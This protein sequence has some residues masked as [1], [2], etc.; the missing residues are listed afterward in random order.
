MRIAIDTVSARAGGGQTYLRNLLSHD[1]PFADMSVTVLAVPSLILPSLGKGVERLDVDPRAANPFLRFMW[2]W[3]VPRLLQD[4]QADVL[5]AP[6]GILAPRSGDVLRV[7]MSRTMLPFDRRQAARYGVGYRRFR[8]AALNRVLLRSLTSADLAVFV[9]GHANK[10]L[11]GQWGVRPPRT[12]VI[13]HGVNRSFAERHRRPDWLPSDPYLVY[14]S[15]IEPYKNHLAV[16]RAFALAARRRPGSEK[17]VLVGR[18]SFRRSA[19][20]LRLELVQLG[21]E[22][23]VILAGE[24]AHHDLPGVYQHAAVGIFAS[25]CENC[26]NVLLEA[27]AAGQALLVSER[28]PMPEFARDAVWYFDPASPDDL[29]GK[30]VDLLEDEE[31][32]R[33]LGTRASET[34]R[35]YDW[36][37]TAGRTWEAIRALAEEPPS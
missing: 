37:T 34:A 12:A 13:P 10:V 17:L 1:L 16:V 7:T 28:P 23:R 8:L 30:L 26:P 19:R 5:F 35:R 27:M 3:Q 18:E 24:I 29:A 32:R 21:L 25:E 22:G 36:A 31:L 4:L 15:N 9:S 14:V 2:Y 20:S 11:A 6:G 33:E